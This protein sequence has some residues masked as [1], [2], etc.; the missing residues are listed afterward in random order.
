MTFSSETDADR[1]MTWAVSTRWAAVL[2]LCLA[3]SAVLCRFLDA[4]QA[5]G[6]ALKVVTATVAL[7]VVPGALLTLLAPPRVRLS[8]LEVIGFGIALSFGVV[9]LL[10]MAAVSAHL[11]PAFVLA[12]MAIASVGIAGLAIRRSSGEVAVSVDELIV[13]VLT[14]ALGVP[15]YLQGSPFDVYEDQVLAAIMRRLSELQAPRLDNLYVAPG[16]VY[17]YPFPARRTSWGWLHGSATSIRCFSITS[18]DSSGAL[19]RS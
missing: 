11:S 16:I 3:A 10:T 14:L 8:M 6:A 12:G 4:D 7:G 19:R 13:L 1:G 18:F 2:A 9:H 17:T 5:S 15:L